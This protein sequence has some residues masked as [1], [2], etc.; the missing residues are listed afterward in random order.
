MEISH[1][2]AHAHAHTHTQRVRYDKCIL[3]ER[4]EKDMEIDG[5]EENV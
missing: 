5:R 1:A 2:H 4:E 3:W